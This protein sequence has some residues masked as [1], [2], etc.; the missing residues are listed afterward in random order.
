VPLAESCQVHFDRAS[1][2][3]QLTGTTAKAR[4]LMH[5]FTESEVESAMDE[6]ELK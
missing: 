1:S 3:D 6:V 2:G 4:K 5:R